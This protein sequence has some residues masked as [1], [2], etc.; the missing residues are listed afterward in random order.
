M[1]LMSVVAE[2]FRRAGVILVGLGLCANALALDVNIA[3]E[4]ELDSVKGLGP[5]STA[6][7]L[8]AREA[9]P[10]QNWADLMKRVKGIRPASAKRLSDAGLT[11]QG[12]PFD[13]NPK[14]EL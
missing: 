6:R 7:I 10:F 12:R 5:A 13:D 9:G 3:N 8:K 1:N 2:R 4:A 14:Q 11:V